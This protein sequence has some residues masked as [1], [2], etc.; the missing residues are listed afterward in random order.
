MNIYQVSKIYQSY[1]NE[2]SKE[3]LTYPPPPPPPPSHTPPPHE[4]L[5]DRPLFMNAFILSS[6][7]TNTDTFANFANSADLEQAVSSGSILFTILLL[8]FD[9]NPYFLVSFLHKS[10]ASRYRPVRVAEGPI[11][12]RYRFIK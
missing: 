6:L 8:I 9:R 7:Q 12:T 2:M 4:S 11:T 1:Q 3:G 5:L 10:T